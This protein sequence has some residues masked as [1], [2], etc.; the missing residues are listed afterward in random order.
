[1]RG[2]SVRTRAGFRFFR[3]L[4]RLFPFDF[5]RD[6]G[7]EME[8][9]F[10]DE[11]MDPD[12][13]GTSNRLRVWSRN[14]AGILRVAPREHLAAAR[15]D[16]VYAF[17][18]MRRA[19]GV[20]VL[21]IL[22][23]AIGIASTTAVFSVV[24]KV[25]LQ[26]LPYKDPAGLIRFQMAYR[27]RLQYPQTVPHFRDFRDS[28]IFEGLATL[29]DNDNMGF[30]LIGDHPPRRISAMQVSSGFFE[31]LGVTPFVGRSFSRDEEEGVHRVAIL[32][33]ALW[34][35]LFGSDRNILEKTIALGVQSYRIVGV[36][37]PGFK[38]PVGG[39][40]DVWVPL[41]TS[42]NGRN[43]WDNYYVSILG[44]LRDG[45][46]IEQ[47]Q[48]EIDQF[49]GTLPDKYP[50]MLRDQRILATS[51][52]DDMAGG[53]R[54]VLLTL[55]GAVGFVL[56]IAIVNGAHLMLARGSARRKEISIRAALGSG[57]GRLIRQLV[58]E[59]LVHALIACALGTAL[60]FV[61]IQIVLVYAP[62]AIIRDN[63]VHFDATVLG[64]ATGLSLLAGVLFGTIPAIQLSRGN[65]NRFLIEND[66]TGDGPASQRTRSLLVAAETAL[67]LVLMVGAALLIQTFQGLVRV[68][69]GIDSAN[70]WTF[71][72]NLPD[73]R[74]Q[75]PSG[76]INF[77]ERFFQRMEAVPGIRAAG[78]ASILPL[79]GLQY[80]WGIRVEGAPAPAPGEPPRNAQM[81]I[82]GGHYFE[83]MGI[84]VIA[85]RKFTERDGE[86]APAVIIVNRAL[87]SKY[88]SGE[89]L[90]RRILV[91]GKPWTIVGIVEDVLND[92]H[93]V[94][95][96]K[97]YYPYAQ[98][99]YDRNWVLTQVISVWPGRHDVLAVAGRELGA[100][101][102]N[103]VIHD[104]RRMDDVALAPI[105]RERFLTFLMSAFSIVG[106][107][108]A[109]IG[110][111]GVLSYMVSRRTHE[112][113]VRMALGAE[114]RHVRTLIMLKGLT[115][116]AAG[117]AIGIVAAIPLVHLLQS[118]VFGVGAAD[119]VTIGITG[120]ILV[121]TAAI[122]CYVPARRAMRIDPIRALR[123]E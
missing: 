81:R 72:F 31:L 85:G 97:I 13:A 12:N 112:I 23:L 63:A 107:A 30:D 1:V 102:S 36:L 47:T 48:A 95:E 59:S 54:G 115:P 94:P 103:L 104:V 79:T 123:M 68:N 119:P 44:R 45:V 34:Q 67:A 25:L 69:T 74:Y 108:L 61:F 87:A 64:V 51:L 43:D 118:I 90:N 8:Q 9:V 18:M 19:P 122:A 6:H 41:D 73:Y 26:P 76:R 49:Y 91:I 60:A 22:T 53:S 56:L 80:L 120:G 50:G 93:G 111:Y 40:I 29:A 2:G 62:T 114:R 11:W 110:V 65:S 84:D 15:S 98:F 83:A 100:L 58:T 77:Y 121:L 106:L 57:R 88:F 116:V 117:G 37:P 55:L 89:A 109:S 17:R 14:L 39:E 20:S 33:H 86:A 38:T 78:A 16:T 24:N 5:R 10:R 96:P 70:V 66:R 7:R 71:V 46:T 42:P 99:A 4:I 75:K 27:D 21:T 35:G 101:D 82:I 32:S 28:G 105:A 113:G 52:H 3:F 92:Q